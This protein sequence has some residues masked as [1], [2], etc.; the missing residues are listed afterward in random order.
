MCCFSQSVR[1]VSSTRIFG[2]L[3]ENKSQ[4][5]AYQ[6]K[7]ESDQAT[8]MILPI[9]VRKRVK[10]R[11]LRFIDLSDYPDFFKDL[12]VSPVQA[13]QSTLAEEGLGRR[14]TEGTQSWRFRAS[15][16]PSTKHFAKLDPRFRYRKIVERIPTYADFSR[17]IPIEGTG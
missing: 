5:I 15:F 11:A 12:M 2:R 4:Y 6:M 7:F 10:Q 8:A 14:G 1:S 3:T 9:P 17:S 13:P 16:V